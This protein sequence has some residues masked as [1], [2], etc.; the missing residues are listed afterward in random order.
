MTVC[1][2]RDHVTQNVILATYENTILGLLSAIV[3]LWL[4]RRFTLPFTLERSL[5]AHLTARN[6]PAN[7]HVCTRSHIHVECVHKTTSRYLM[8]RMFPVIT[9]KR[10]MPSEWDLHHP[11]DRVMCVMLVPKL[12]IFA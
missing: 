1:R 2:K 10:Y 7:F 11:I 3:Y 6:T 9:R 12:R 4:V 8:T 5:C